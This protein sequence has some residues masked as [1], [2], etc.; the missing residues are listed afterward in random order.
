MGW[1]FDFCN[2]S[3]N[4]KDKYY[5]IRSMGRKMDYR[6]MSHIWKVIKKVISLH[7]WS[8]ND[9]I[10]ASTCEVPGLEY[11]YEAGILSMHEYEAFVCLYDGNKLIVLE[12][13]IE[14]SDALREIK[15][16]CDMDNYESTNWGYC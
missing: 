4:E 11:R 8:D 6:P 7:G 1:D 5:L 10:S 3:R 13:D 2:E 9:I 16:S 12:R 14:H 15:C